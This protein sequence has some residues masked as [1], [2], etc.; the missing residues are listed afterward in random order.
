MTFS[1]FLSDDFLLLV[2]FFALF[3]NYLPKCGHYLKKYYYFCTDIARRLTLCYRMTIILIQN[4]MMKRL[5]TLMLLTMAVITASAIPD[6]PGL[7][8]TLKTATGHT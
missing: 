5:L 6:E 4:T 7:W 8:R 3:I 2:I 1:P